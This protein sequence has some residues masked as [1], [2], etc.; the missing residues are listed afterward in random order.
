MINPRRPVTCHNLWQSKCRRCAQLLHGDA[1]HTR[2]YLDRT[3]RLAELAAFRGDAHICRVQATRSCMLRLYGR[4]NDNL[5]H[6]TAP[7]TDIRIM[8]T[9]HTADWLCSKPGAHPSMEAPATSS[10]MSRPSR[11][12]SMKHVSSVSATPRR[13]SA[14]C[15]SDIPDQHTSRS[16]QRIATILDRMRPPA[17]PAWNTSPASPRRPDAAQRPVAESRPRTAQVACLQFPRLMSR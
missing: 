8:K 5:T 16:Q 12:A 13:S 4:T 10:C 14:T 15:R 9:R 2:K 17:V 6:T 1:T 7:N 3:A 11:R